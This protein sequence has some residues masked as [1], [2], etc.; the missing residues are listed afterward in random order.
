MRY[1]LCFL[2]PFLCTCASAQPLD[3]TTLTFLV[4]A[5]TKLDTIFVQGFGNMLP[6]VEVPVKN[7]KGILKIPAYSVD[8]F[9]I[10]GFT[11]SGDFFNL[12]NVLEGRQH[13][14]EISKKADEISCLLISEDTFAVYLKERGEEIQKIQHT[15]SLFYYSLQALEENTDNFYAL[16][17][18]TEAYQNVG[19]SQQK[20]AD[21]KAVAD[22]IQ[23][24]LSQHYSIK[25]TYDAIL[26]RIN[27]EY[28][29]FSDYK[30]LTPDNKKEH[31][32]W[33]N[34]EYVVIDYWFVACPPCIKDQ[35]EMIADYKSGD[36]P[37]NATFI[38]ICYQD[39]VENWKTFIAEK[40]VPWLNYL[41]PKKEGVNGDG[42][43][44]AKSIGAG[45]F[46]DYYLFN[47]AGEIVD[48]FNTYEEVK[49]YLKEH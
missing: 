49:T 15:D 12:Q 6:S 17:A 1:L 45:P 20:L 11:E 30:F 4:D 46:P 5:E 10:Q 31:L 34:T 24:P 26:N 22:K 14:F 16:F 48:L 27:A 18:L 40:N 29:S 19:V 35:K 33:P 47:Q 3:T 32:Q 42:K 36:K 44:Y 38:S 28:D 7:G 37:N 9:M 2:I 43:T 23:P 25:D 8:Y 41:E 13:T 39:D 21:L